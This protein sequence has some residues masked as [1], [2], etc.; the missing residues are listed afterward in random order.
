MEVDRHRFAGIDDLSGL[1]AEV[2][3]PARPLAKELSDLLRP[4]VGDDFGEGAD[5]V[6]LDVVVEDR[7]QGG[8]PRSDRGPNRLDVL[9]RHRL[10]RLRQPHG[11]ETSFGSRNDSNRM[12]F[13]PWNV[14]T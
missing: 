14:Q 11:F 12:T 4:V 1:E 6:L 9:L 5:I 8:C 3:E 13:P 2:V 10:L 7:Q